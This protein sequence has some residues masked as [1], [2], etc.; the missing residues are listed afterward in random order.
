MKL[1]VSYNIFDGEELLENS[2]K[3]IRENVDYISVVYQEVSNFGN[4]CDENLVTLLKSLKKEGL[5]DEL[6]KYR[7]QPQRG[8]HFNEITKRNIGVFLSQGNGCTHHMAMD[9]DEF[10]TTEQ[11]KFLKTTVLEGDYDSSVS[12]M[13]TYYKKPIYQLDPKEDYYVS[14]IFKIDDKS[15]YELGCPFPVLVDPTRR[16]V[17]DK[18]KIFTREEI[19]MHHMSF[20]RNNINTK[21]LNSSANSSF[22]TIIPKIVD[23]YNNWEYPNDVMWASGNLLKVKKVKNLFNVE[24]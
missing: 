16:M 4:P 7:P 22:N 24:L 6:H 2:I 1:G 5:I 11:F 23:Y 14:L 17:S 10:Y 9:S 18:C 3:S 19:E 21:L 8:G 15:K 12:Q 13:C 20:V